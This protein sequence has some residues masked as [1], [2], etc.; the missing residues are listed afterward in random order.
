MVFPHGAP[1]LV[2]GTSKPNRLTLRPRCSSD[3]DALFSTMSDPDA[4]RWWSHAPFE[5]VEELREYFSDDDQSN[6]QSWAI[7]RA[8]EQLAIGFVSAGQKREGVFEIGYFLAPEAQGNG[9]AREAV[10]L[11]IDRLFAEGN[12]AFSPTPIR[13][14]NHRSRC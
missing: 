13:I 14:I 4:M 2:R 12:D 11:L 8:D 3:A 7:V 10:T 5:H 6:W 1:A 9:Y